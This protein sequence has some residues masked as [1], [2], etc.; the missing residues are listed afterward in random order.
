[1]QDVHVDFTTKD[2]FIGIP[3]KRD[4][5]R[6]PRDYRSVRMKRDLYNNGFLRVLAKVLYLNGDTEKEHEYQFAHNYSYYYVYGVIRGLAAND[7][8]Y[9][10]QIRKEEVPA[11][12]QTIHSPKLGEKV[13]QRKMLSYAEQ[14]PRKYEYTLRDMFEGFLIDSRGIDVA[15]RSL[16]HAFPEIRDIIT[17]ILD[18]IKYNAIYNEKWKTEI[19][20]KIRE[21]YHE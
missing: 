15:A 11:F 14:E 5:Q 17:E 12:F 9:E 4:L 2:A 21:N 8:N 13:F 16:Y 20:D 3:S 18:K 19:V 1:M 7:G 10:K 6:R